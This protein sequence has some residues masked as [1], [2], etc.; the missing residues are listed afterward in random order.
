MKSKEQLLSLYS[1]AKSYY[2]SVDYPDGYKAKIF[3]EPI[4]QE[5]KESENREQEL[6]WLGE[7]CS[8]ILK[9]KSIAD[10]KLPIHV[11]EY[12]FRSLDWKEAKPFLISIYNSTSDP[13]VKLDLEVIIKKHLDQ[14]WTGGEYTITEFEPSIWDLVE[15][16]L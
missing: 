15:E 5:L 14:N 8:T 9:P 11:F 12:C 16:D 10:Y 4:K 2:E 13:S 6:K 7:L 3:L 1:K